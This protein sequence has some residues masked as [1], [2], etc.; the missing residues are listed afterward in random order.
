MNYYFAKL[1]SRLVAFLTPRSV[2]ADSS[3]IGVRQCGMACL[4]VASFSRLPAPSLPCFPP[5]RQEQSGISV[6]WG[7]FTDAETT[8]PLEGLGASAVGRNGLHDL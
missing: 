7:G 4:T 2:H 8:S 1:R 6:C 3:T 5:S